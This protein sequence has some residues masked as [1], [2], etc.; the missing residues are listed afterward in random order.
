MF[1]RSRRVFAIIFVI[2]VLI[3]SALIIF[4]TNANTQAFGISLLAGAIISVATLWIEHI[5]SGEQVRSEELLRSGILAVYERRDLVDEYDKYVKG[6]AKI[7]VAG[8]TLTA[9]TESNEQYFRKRAQQGKPVD[10]RMLL[11]DP[12][13]EWARAMEATEEKAPGSYAQAYEHILAKLRDIPGI[14]LR[15]LRRPLPMMVYAID[16]VVY[17][18][19]Y[20]HRGA[21]RMATTLKLGGGGWLYERQLREFQALWEVGVLV[22]FKG[23]QGEVFENS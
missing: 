6:C 13:S 21:S 22:P 8:Y 15:L 17:T 11:V 10:V 1:F 5:R 3:G 7:A 9:F 2:F 23:T 12:L 18:G 4:S 19:P 16:Q 14:E 20:P